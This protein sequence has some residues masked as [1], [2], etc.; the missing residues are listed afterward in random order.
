MN[1]HILYLASGNSR[2]FGENKLLYSFRGKPLFRWGLDMLDQYVKNHE[3]CTLT[4]V[5][6][7]EEIRSTAAELGILSVDSPESEKGISYTM[8]A[9]LRSLGELPPEDFVVFVVSDQP[10]LTAESLERLLAY[11]KEGTETASMACGDRP[12]NP[13]LF[14]VK[15]VPELMALEG[16]KGGRAVIRKHDC[17]FVQVGSEKE[18]NDIDLKSDL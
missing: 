6:Q 10:F 14:S 4:V 18:L 15:L 7:Y 13:T 12:G 3:T 2:R 17:V 1:K 9:G 11:A 16:D 5:S 8:K